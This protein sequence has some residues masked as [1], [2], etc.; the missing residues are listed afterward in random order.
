MADWGLLDDTGALTDAGQQLKDHVESTTDARSLLVLDALSDDEVETLFQAI[1]PITRTVV[2]GGDVP[3]MTPMALRRNELDDSSAHLGVHPGQRLVEHDAVALVVVDHRAA[4][5]GVVVRAPHDAA[6][7]VFDGL[8]RCVDVVGLDA[9]DDLPGNGVV[10]LGREGE[11]DGP[12]VE[13]GE[14]GAVAKLQRPCRGFRR[15]T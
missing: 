12:A 13:G 10:Y 3:A 9:D 14:V 15:R 5:V 6:A 11:G 2:A 4:L 7:A 8:C 1:T